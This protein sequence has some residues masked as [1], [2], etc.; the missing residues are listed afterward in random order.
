MHAENAITCFSHV[1]AASEQSVRPLPHSFCASN[2]SPQPAMVEPATSAAQ[3][4]PQL[5]DESTPHWFSI[6]HDVSQS[7]V[8][9]TR[10]QPG[11]RSAAPIAIASAETKSEEDR[12]KAREV[13]IIGPS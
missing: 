9:S 13:R 11:A 10:K 5:P 6:L 1:V 12:A 3:Y 2:S 7:C 4:V 8:D